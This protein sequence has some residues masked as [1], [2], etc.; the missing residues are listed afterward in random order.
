MCEHQQR[1][2]KHVYSY[3]VIDFSLQLFPYGILLCAHCRWL[4]KN[5]WWLLIMAPGEHFSLSLSSSVPLIF[6]EP[7]DGRKG[8][9]DIHV[10]QSGL[11]VCCFDAPRASSALAL[12]KSPH[13]ISSATM[14]LGSDY[15]HRT[16]ACLGSSTDKQISL[17]A[18]G[19]ANSKQWKYTGTC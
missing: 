10:S 8:Q 12:S 1:S 15:E 6:S 16:A 9:H 19:N 2:I 7:A 14:A 18:R 3:N 11:S 4:H 17:A 5:C 13:Y